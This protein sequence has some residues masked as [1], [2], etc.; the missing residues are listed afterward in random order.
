MKQL[1]KGERK[2]LSI[3][4]MYKEYIKQFV[5]WRKLYQ[6]NNLVPTKFFHNQMLKYAALTDLMCRL[7]RSNEREI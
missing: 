4:W 7:Q 2:M 1:N 3:D 5:Y 6:D